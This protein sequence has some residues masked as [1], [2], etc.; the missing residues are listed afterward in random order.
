MPMLTSKKKYRNKRKAYC[1]IDCRVTG[2]RDLARP[3]HRMLHGDALIY[4]S[5]ET[6]EDISEMCRW[7]L[8]WRWRQGMTTE[9]AKRCSSIYEGRSGNGYMTCLVATWMLPWNAAPIP[10]RRL[11]K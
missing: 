7:V 6:Y 4:V 1:H 11:K 2:Y 3:A 8:P 9:I 10:K 5:E